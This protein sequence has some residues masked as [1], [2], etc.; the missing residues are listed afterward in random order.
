MGMTVSMMKLGFL[1][2]RTCSY[3]FPCWRTRFPHFA[4]S[5][6]P[7]LFCLQS[8]MRKTPQHLSFR[9]MLFP[10]P[11]FSLFSLHNPYF[12]PS[13]RPNRQFSLRTSE[14]WFFAPSENGSKGGRE[15][16]RGP[17]RVIIVGKNA[18][19]LWTILISFVWN[20]VGNVCV[21]TVIERMC[22]ETKKREWDDDDDDDAGDESSAW[23]V[24]H[25]S[26]T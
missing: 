5:P 11:Y 8:A 13:D 7:S 22:V 2:A 21:V 6:L 24:P 12:E 17:R 19:E 10:T 25:C 26:P 9:C 3:L 1:F 23:V 4:Y 16:G 20:V 18:N 15:E 14:G